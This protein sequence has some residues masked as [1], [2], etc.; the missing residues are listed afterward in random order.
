MGRLSPGCP[1]FASGIRALLRSGRII[2]PDG[3]MSDEDFSLTMFAADLICTPYPRH[4]GSASIVIRAAAAERPVLGSDFG[5][6]GYVVP[7]FGLG[8]ICNVTDP[9]VFAAALR[10]SLAD[11]HLFR[12]TE[13]GRRFVAFHS[14]D[15]YRATWTLRLRRQWGLP[16]SEDQRDWEWVL[17]GSQSMAPGLAPASLAR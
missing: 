7:R 5:W 15:N 12:L 8:R 2:A 1:L 16:D 3:Y 10:D 9:A 14:P 11:A 4:I 13:S 17:A 6:I